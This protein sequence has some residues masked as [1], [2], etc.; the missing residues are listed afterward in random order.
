MIMFAKWI[1]KLGPGLI[2][3]AADD[4]PSGIATYSQAGAQFGLSMLW[5][6]VITYPLMVAM[7]IISARIGRVSGEG[8]A[9]NIRIH[10]P[11]P[12]LYLSISLLFMAN[13]VNIGADVVAM[14]D[15]LKLL[16]G[17]NT[18]I[19]AVGF[20]L[21]SLLLQ[22]LVPYQ[23]Y[24]RFLKWL[25]LSLLAYVVTVFIL[26]TPWLKVSYQ[27][28]HP[29]VKWSKDYLTTLVAIFGTTISPYLFFWQASEEVE[30]LQ[31]NKTQKPLIDA[32]DQAK[33]Q[34]NRI[35]LD[36]AIGM[37]FSNI[38]AFCIMLTAAIALN[39]NG[40][41]EVN[42]SADAAKALEPV[43]GQ[44]AFFLFAVGIIGT[45]MLAVPVL[46][47][48]AAYAMAGSFNWNCS[49]ELA[50]GRAKRFYFVIGIS[51]LLGVGLCF[52]PIDPIKALY[53]SA[54]INGILA[55]PIMILLMLMSNNQK[56]MGDFKLTKLLSY[57]GWICTMLMAVAVIGMIGAS[58]Y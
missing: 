44:F 2:T 21:V 19:Y 1:E 33:V 50:P 46:A 48:S 25:T 13:I 40:I 54:V 55:V 29:D 7:Q 27:L 22:I 56:V 58:L 45:G 18:V 57:S 34:F 37:G 47:G 15:A 39:A 53:W 20:G 8:I 35:R 38:V 6:L 23:K 3:G 5:S 28:I 36:T 49:L 12:I 26:K 11:H 52:T 4:D 16:I 51:T 17:G 31:L 14:G 24:V 30:D 32:P 41:F 9:T 43:A 42:T 10:Y